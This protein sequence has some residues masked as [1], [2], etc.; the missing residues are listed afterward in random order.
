MA[1]INAQAKELEALKV[2]CIQICF[3]LTL[4][5]SL[6]HTHTH[7]HTHYTILYYHCV[8]NSFRIVLTIRSMRTTRR[9]HCNKQLHSKTKSIYSNSRFNEWSSK[10]NRNI[11]RTGHTILNNQWYVKFIDK[12]TEN[13]NLIQTYYCRCHSSE[14]SNTGIRT[15]KEWPKQ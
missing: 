1:A 12:S 5:L 15:R 7:T 6:S 8:L 14:K 9:Q 3:R 2:T 13:N 10:I 11:L 4:S